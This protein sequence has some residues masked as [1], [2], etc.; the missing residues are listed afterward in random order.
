MQQLIKAFAIAGAGWITVSASQPSSQDIQDTKLENIE[1]PKLQL[2]DTQLEWPTQRENVGLEV[3]KFRQSFA[4]RV[5]SNDYTGK[6]NQCFSTRSADYDPAKAKMLRANS[7]RYHKSGAFTDEQPIIVIDPGH[8]HESSLAEAGYD[9]GGIHEATGVQEARLVEK[10][11]FELKA[12]LEEK[13]D[14]IVVMTR[15][16][17]GH[18]ESLPQKTSLFK[19]QKVA[20]QV[21]AETASYL[22]EKF[23]NSEI[24]FV[25]LHTNTGNVPGSE[26]YYYA[27]FRGG[28]TDSPESKRLAISI[29][30][31]Y[32]LRAGAPA[33]AL[34]NDYAVL[35][36]QK[37]PSVLAELGSIDV[38]KDRLALQNPKTIAAQ[39]ANGIESYFQE[40]YKARVQYAAAKKE[41]EKWQKPANSIVLASNEP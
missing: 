24:I 18:K 35:R 28:G 40:S 10:I 26:I 8:G 3:Q 23:P 5:R 14:A 31:H 27:P 41:M 7:V 25:S 11:A 2:V 34:S 6:W 17:A 13:N 4:A 36:C 21:R 22:A 9:T 33:Y 37:V 39:L 38:E 15:G 12:T 16:L 1:A 32:R 29:N 30:S 20:L 19:N